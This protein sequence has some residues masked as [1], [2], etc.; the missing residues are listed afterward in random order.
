MAESAAAI[1]SQAWGLPLAWSRQNA[2]RVLDT[3]FDRGI[4]FLSTWQAWRSDPLRPRMLHYVALTRTP[5]AFEELRSA[6]AS[7]PDLLALARVL[8]AQWTDLQPGFHRLTFDKGQVLL[9]LCVGDNTAAL[10]RQQQFAADS[11]YLDCDPPSD[12]KES[13]AWDLWTIKALARC[14]RRGARLASP[15]GAG[16]L[17]PELTQCGFEL[18]NRPSEPQTGPLPELL[19]AEFNPRWTLKQTRGPSF[20]QAAAIIGTCAVIGAGLAGASVAAALARRGWQVQ[21]LDQG[22]APAAGA[23]G[24]PMGL[25]VPHVSA[26]DCALSRLSRSGVRLMLHQARSLLQ[27]G[28][29]WDAT[30]ALERRVDGNP[31]ASSIWHSQAAWLK[32]APLVQAW[33]AQPGITFQGGARVASLRQNGDQWELLDAQ[34]Q[35]LASA[36]RVVFA[37]AQGLAALLE[38][39]QNTL[40]SFG[41]RRE[42]LPALFGVRGQLSWGLHQ[43]APDAAFPP[44]P[45]NGAGSVIPCVPVDGGA[46]WYV[47]SSYQPDTRPESPI[48]KNHSA[49]F[50]RLQKLLP[51]LAQV[52]EPQF[53]AG[54]LNAWKSTRCVTADR[55]PLVG[56]L[57]EADDPSLWVCAGMGSRGLSFSV[58]CAELLAA[59]WGAEPLPLDAGLAASLTALRGK[60]AAAANA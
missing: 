20:D 45:V 50:G 23:S 57:Y 41:I 60:N 21:V 35:T 25:V 7:C 10:L 37:N 31:D 3:R 58:L 39:L 49:N 44:W 36:N 54:R 48:E 32:P 4:Q 47:G 33:L 28:Q 27:P 59:R 46:A 2:W 1:L 15:F 26:D 5:L 29:D 34:G 55:L 11:V 14:C 17:L 12:D 40:P 16:A 51:E 56:P 19:I 38:T 22:D 13:A 8:V 53:A 18:P 30:G 52:L 42:Q 43:E 24:L 9:T 6:A